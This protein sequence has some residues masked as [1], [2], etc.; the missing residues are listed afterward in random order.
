MAAER[1]VVTDF[2]HRGGRNLALQ[3]QQVH[4]RVGVAY[5]VLD[6]PQ[7]RSRRQDPGVGGAGQETAEGQVGN[8]RVCVTRHPAGQT[9]VQVEARIAGL[10]RVEY[11]ETGAYGPLRAWVVGNSEARGPVAVIGLHQAVPEPA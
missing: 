10:H 6:A 8:V 5:V 1:A 2:D 11:A 7:E 9:A 3:V 4:H